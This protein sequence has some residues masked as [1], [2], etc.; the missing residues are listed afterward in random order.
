MKKIL[1]SLI[2]IIGV[3][4]ASSIT[5]CVGCHGKD[6]EKHALGKSKVV[7]DMNLTQISTALKGYKDGTYG[8]AM[9]AVMKGQV[10]DSNITQILK[11]INSSRN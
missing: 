5:K 9:K 10:K 6:F 7:K 8:G 1:I 11:D 3:L 4:G 2:L